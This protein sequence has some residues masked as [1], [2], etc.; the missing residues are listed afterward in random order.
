MHHFEGENDKIFL[1]RGTA[2]PSL[3]PTPLGRR[4]PPPQ[5]PP[6]STPSAF[7]VNPALLYHSSVYYF[8][9]EIVNPG[10]VHFVQFRLH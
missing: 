7:L 10:R 5:T 9:L 3:D 1:G 2:A 6:P 4:I 8:G